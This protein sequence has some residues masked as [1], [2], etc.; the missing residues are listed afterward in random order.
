MT[1]GI[2]KI[3]NI[4]VNKV[5]I[6]SSKDIEKRL[7]QHFGML[8]GN[9]HHSVKLQ[10][11]YEKYGKDN[12]VTEVVEE[13][14]QDQ[15]LIR[16]QVWM[17]LLDVYY[18]G[19]NCSESSSYPTSTVSHSLLDK[20]D[21]WIVKILSDFVDIQNMR[22][23]IVEDVFISI[24]PLRSN[25]GSKSAIFRRYS[26]ATSMVKAILEDSKSLD[27]DK[28]YRISH[29][30]YMNKEAQYYLGEETSKRQ[31]THSRY[32][33]TAIYDRLIQL[34]FFD[35]NN[36]KYLKTIGKEL[37]KQGIFFPPTPDNVPPVG[38]WEA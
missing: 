23:E 33:T 29:I 20:G 17:D 28:E 25:T 16:E 15:L 7:K 37:K 27:R 32:K 14:T 38:G 12:F 22:A 3:T 13:C 31:W 21:K 30:H 34:L 18:S 19:Y 9:R 24:P 1:C 6:G 2:Y 5:Y 10:R 35:M 11:A 26:R 4:A 8:K 36:C